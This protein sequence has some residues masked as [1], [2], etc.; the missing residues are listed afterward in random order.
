MSEPSLTL[1]NVLDEVYARQLQQELDDEAWAV[2]RQLSAEREAR[3]HANM[4]AEDKLREE[5]QRA[6][7]EEAEKEAARQAEDARR[8]ERELVELQLKTI[9]L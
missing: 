9:Q 6:A 2:V 7:K 8:F 1:D 4:S 3:R 5:R